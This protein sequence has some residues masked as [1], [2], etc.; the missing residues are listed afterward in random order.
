MYQDED[1]SFT[2]SIQR[3]T[4]VYCS[5]QVHHPYIKENLEFIPDGIDLR[6]LSLKEIIELIYRSFTDI[7][8]LTNFEDF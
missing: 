7:S 1:I 4:R 3:D 6:Q 2:I 5:R 8:V